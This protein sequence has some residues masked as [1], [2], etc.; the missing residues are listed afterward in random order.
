MHDA[1]SQEQTPK[2]QE[3]TLLAPLKGPRFWK[4][5]NV[6]NLLSLVGDQLFPSFIAQGQNFYIF[7]CLYSKRK[8]VFKVNM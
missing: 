3:I 2:R 4:E 5:A 6:T 8:L 7:Y 1:R